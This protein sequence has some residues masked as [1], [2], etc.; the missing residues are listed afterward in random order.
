MRGTMAGGDDCGICAG[1]AGPGCFGLYQVAGRQW[2]VQPTFRV[3]SSST[4]SLVW[5]SVIAS[6]CRG[7]TRASSSE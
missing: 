6:G 3:A 4:R 7:S 5:R 2:Q 1:C